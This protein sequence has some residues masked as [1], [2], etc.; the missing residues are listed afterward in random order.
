MLRQAVT[1]G[2]DNLLPRFGERCMSVVREKMAAI[3]S[4]ADARRQHELLAMRERMIHHGGM[5]A[6]MMA[7][8]NGRD[9]YDAY[10]IPAWLQQKIDRGT[11]TVPSPTV[12]AS[13]LRR[14]KELRLSPRVQA[15]NSHPATDDLAV[16]HQ[17]QLQA[18]RE[19]GLHD[20]TIHMLRAAHDAY[21]SDNSVSEGI[22]QRDGSDDLSCPGNGMNVTAQCDNNGSLMDNGG[23]LEIP[24]YRKFNRCEQGS[25][26]VGDAIPDIALH[27]PDGTP[28]ALSCFQTAGRPLVLFAG[29]Y[30]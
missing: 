11:A 4:A 10:R 13:I 15:A 17:L 18:V 30:T 26:L 3:R 12:M 2:H 22:A 14:E 24:H 23:L 5:M 29:S 19:H 9:G 21:S 6:R 1:S 16:T 8:M 27:L 7:P 28:T 25:M 20:D